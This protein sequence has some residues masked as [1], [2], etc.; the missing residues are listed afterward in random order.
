[1]TNNLK[2]TIWLLFL[3]FSCGNAVNQKPSDEQNQATVKD[4][5]RL[6]SITNLTTEIALFNEVQSSHIG[7]GGIESR[8]YRD[9]QKLVD[10]TTEDELLQ[11]T[12]D[13]NSTV[14]TYAAF[15]LISRNSSYIP[16]VLQFS[17][18]RDKTV[19]CMS[20]CIKHSDKV[21][22]M[23][24]HEYWNHIKFAED[25]DS[26]SISKDPAL[27]KMDSIMLEHGP[28]DWFTYER[29]FTNR[30]FPNQ[31]IKLI[32]KVAFDELNVFAIDYLFK[33]DL[34][35]YSTH[36]QKT[37]TNIMNGEIL[38]PVYYDKI[39]KMLLDYKKEDLNAMVLSKT[40]EIDANFGMGKAKRYDELLDQY[41]LKRK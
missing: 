27:V 15:G 33:T 26:S 37:L 35:S 40:K 14:A 38:A 41:G 34:N 18:E 11:L 25:S 9:Y 1:M 16:S 29:I 8:Q 2:H 7:A 30:Q 19:K 12:R 21:S 36:I 32:E 22:R 39:F 20:G 10:I 31:Y 13:T 6:D 4:Q 23:I 5:A 28:H 24:Y 17:L 3:F